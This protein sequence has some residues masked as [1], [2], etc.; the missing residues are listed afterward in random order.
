MRCWPCILILL[1]LSAGCGPKL[2]QSDLGAITY[3]E[4]PKV[5]GADKPY[6]LPQ[7]GPP[8]EDKKA[9]KE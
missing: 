3:D 1:A 6:P 8:S 4:A 9:D 2:S 5:K 7:L